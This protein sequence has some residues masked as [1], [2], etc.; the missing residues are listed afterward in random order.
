MKKCSKCNNIKEFCDFSKN[1]T[2]KDGYAKQCKSCKKEYYLKDREKVIA[3]TK[4]WKIENKEAD[5]LHTKKYR[6]R[7]KGKRNALTAKRRASKLQATPKWLTK[8]QLDDIRQIYQDVQD[9]Q[10]LAEEKL[11]VD[12]I[13]ALQGENVCGLHVPWNLQILTLKEKCQKGNKH[14]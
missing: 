14:D 5:K 1:K 2:R 7:N 6:D 12:H 8:E 11:S 4:Q 9:I 13:I 10:W 3:R